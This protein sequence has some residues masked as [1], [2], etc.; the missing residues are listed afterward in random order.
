M[1]SIEVLQARLRRTKN[2]DKRIDQQ[3]EIGWMLIRKDI[4]SA[5][6]TIESMLEEYSRTNNRRGIA[7]AQI[8]L[9]YVAFLSG[10]IMQTMEVLLRAK[11][12]FD[13]HCE[14]MYVCD[15]NLALSHTYREMG[16][17]DIALNLGFIALEQLDQIPIARKRLGVLLNLAVIHNRISDFKGALRYGYDTLHTAQETSNSDYEAHAYAVLSGIFYSVGD[18]EQSIA[19]QHRALELYEQIKHGPGIVSTTINLSDYCAQ[20]KDT[21]SALQLALRAVELCAKMQMEKRILPTCLLNLS[22]VY[23]KMN[24]YENAKQY[25]TEALIL[26]KQRNMKYDVSMSQTLLGEIHR[27][28]FNNNVAKDFFLEA[29]GAFEGHERIKEKIVILKHLYSLFEAE[30]DYQSALLYEKQLSDALLF[31]QKEQTHRD[32]VLLQAQLNQKLIEQERDEYKLKA[33]QAV[34]AFERQAA[35]LSELS[36]RLTQRR[37]ALLSCL[38]DIKQMERSISSKELYTIKAKIYVEI[39]GDY[40]LEQFD[41][42]VSNLDSEFYSR[43]SHKHPELSKMETKICIL[44]KME[45][46]SPQIATVLY[47][48]ERTV[49]THRLHIRKKLKLSSKD[50]IHSY[51]DSI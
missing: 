15:L 41:Q 19:L 27:E 14:I 34:Q 28:L 31:Q 24:N 30:C 12:F 9:G 11:E 38:E 25:A 2:I 50:T 48:G 3:Y 21:E 42:I 45:L 5:R 43:L 36:T 18:M 29:L 33:M 26:Y 23:A 51:L 17:Y 8:L 44:L 49:E 7:A 47:I 20:N 22:S 4:T 39:N 37:H 35:E 10:E 32:I 46:T 13:A 1:V 40:H 16:S 6:V